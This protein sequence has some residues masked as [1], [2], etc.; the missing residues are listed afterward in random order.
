[1]DGGTGQL[2]ESKLSIHHFDKNAYS[3]MNVALAMQVLSA[4]A[5]S[6][7]R[8]AI[9]DEDVTLSL[10]NKAM[11]NHLANLCEKMNDLADICNGRNG[12]HTP[13][14]AEERQTKLLDI[15]SWFAEWKELHDERVAKEEATEYNFFADETYFCIQALILAQV[16]AIQLYCVEKGLSVAPRTM[17]T[18]VVEWHFGDVRSFIGGSTNK[19]TAK[20]YDH[21]DFKAMACNAAKHSLRGNNA[22][23]DGMFGRQ[24]RH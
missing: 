14:N 19:I 1:M 21:G 3:R 8:A 11:Y 10:E 20:G 5:A 6:M 18:D 16:G 2:E 15:L 7:I 24:K 9:A 12:P 17:N 23:G 22:S 4:T 13:E